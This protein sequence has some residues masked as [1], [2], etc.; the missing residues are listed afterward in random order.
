M[1]FKR[2]SSVFQSAA[3]T[4]IYQNLTLKVLVTSM[5][6]NVNGKLK[7]TDRVCRKQ[8]FIILKET[9]AFV[10]PSLHSEMWFVSKILP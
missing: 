10:V 1:Y 6:G 8:T 3:V 4:N 7:H 9:K 5:K 2:V